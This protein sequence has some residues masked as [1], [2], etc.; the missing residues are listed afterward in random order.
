MRLNND[1]LHMFYFR[2]IIFSIRY[3]M[4]TSSFYKSS[5]LTEATWVNIQNIQKNGVFLKVT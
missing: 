2:E 1:I 5:T 3:T 4:T